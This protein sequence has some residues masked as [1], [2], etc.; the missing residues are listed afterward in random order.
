MTRGMLCPNACAHHRIRVRPVGVRWLGGRQAS[1]E[2]LTWTGVTRFKEKYA[3][4]MLLGGRCIA[5]ADEIIGIEELGER[6][7][8]CFQTGTHNYVADGFISHNCYVFCEAYQLPGIECYT[9]FK[10]N[11]DARK[12][13]AIFPTTPDRPWVEIFHQH[14]HGDPEFPDWQCVCGVARDVNPTSFDASQKEKDRKLM[15]RE[16][17][18]IHYEGQIGRYIGSVFNYQRGQRQFTTTTHPDC[19]RDPANGSVIEN[20]QIPAHWETFGAADTGTF[21]AGL[22]AALSP[23]GDLLFVYEQPNYRYIGGKHE[24]LDGASIAT[25]KRDMRRA[26]DAARVRDLRADPNSQW[27]RELLSEPNGIHLRA[28]TADLEQRTEVL[29]EYFQHGKVFLAPWLEVLPYE[30]EQA[31]WPDDTTAGGRYRRVKKQDHTLDGAEHIAACRPRSVLVAERKP[32][33]WIEEF[34]GHALT[35]TPTANPHMGIH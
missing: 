25:W 5:E 19:W 28:G 9:D 14:G 8:Y 6:E 12:G 20:F 29:R 18:G 4:Q 16:K 3:D 7:V 2:F 17:F 24:F 10:Q 27:K 13:Y 34:T 33:L 15:T 30:L 21:T 22:L 23:T 32:K 1:L 11:L 31:Q 35:S 26:M